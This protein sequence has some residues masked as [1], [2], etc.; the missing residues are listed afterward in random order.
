MPHQ[1]N[2][3]MKNSSRMYRGNY[4]EQHNQYRFQ[5]TFRCSCPHNCFAQYRKYKYQNNCLELNMTYMYPNTCLSMYQSMCPYNRHNNF[6]ALNTTY[7]FRNK[8]LAL[9]KKCSCQ[10]TC[11]MPNN[12]RNRRDSFPGWCSLRRY[13]GMFP[14]KCPNMCPDMFLYMIPYSRHS[15]SPV[16]HMSCMYL[17]S[18]P[19]PNMKYMYPNMFLVLSML[20]RYP[21]MCRCKL[22]NN[23]QTRHKTDMCPGMY[24]G[25]CQ[26]MFQNMSRRNSSARN[27]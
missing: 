3:L 25:K 18:F 20:H 1:Y 4:P 21:N 2:H 26:N 5:S 12:S 6:L 7:M 13:F 8:C 9:S 22:C 17:S 14:S 11:L 27:N 16:Q 24:F 23:C 15:N 19:V 10:N